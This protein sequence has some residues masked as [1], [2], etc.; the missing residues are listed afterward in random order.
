MIN[1]EFKLD[2]IIKIKVIAL[3]KN[4]LETKYIGREPFSTI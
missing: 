1:V 4:Y 2:L 3:K